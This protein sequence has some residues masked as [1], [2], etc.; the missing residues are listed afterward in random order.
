MAETICD[1]TQTFSMIFNDSENQHELFLSTFLH[2][3]LAS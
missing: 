3:T 2:P 1:A